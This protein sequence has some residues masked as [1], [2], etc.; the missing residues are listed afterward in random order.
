M[1]F[2]QKSEDTFAHGINIRNNYQL[3]H[4]S[5]TNKLLEKLVWVKYSPIKAT[6]YGNVE[7]IKSIKITGPFI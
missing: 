1:L 4:L 5:S 2:S 6:L 3:F 7:R